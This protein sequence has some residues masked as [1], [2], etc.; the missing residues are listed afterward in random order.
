[1]LLTPFA[2]RYPADDIGT[3]FD[4]LTGV[5]GSFASGKTLNND[6]GIFID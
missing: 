5:E 4:H 2:R 6:F 1:M 3:V